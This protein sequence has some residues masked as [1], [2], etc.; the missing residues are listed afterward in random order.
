MCRAMVFWDWRRE[1][2]GIVGLV[3]GAL[4]RGRTVPALGTCVEGCR[5]ARTRVQKQT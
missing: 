2:V 4:A 1:R 5:G 3:I